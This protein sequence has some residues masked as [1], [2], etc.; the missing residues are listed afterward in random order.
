LTFAIIAG[1]ANNVSSAAS[2]QGLAGMRC[3][4]SL[5]PWL[6]GWQQHAL[7]LNPFFCIASPSSS[8]SACLCETAH[9]KCTHTQTQ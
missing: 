2:S 3:S 7:H 5:P 1:N 9:S 6:P 4:R 8:C